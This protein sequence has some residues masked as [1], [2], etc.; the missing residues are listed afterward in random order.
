L[1][2]SLFG[3]EADHFFASLVVGVGQLS[4]SASALNTARPSSLPLGPGRRRWPR[5]GIP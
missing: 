2:L 3:G 1:A 4:R 5:F